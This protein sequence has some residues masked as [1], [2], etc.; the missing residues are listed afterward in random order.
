MCA[1]PAPAPLAAGS[2]ALRRVRCELRR[3]GAALHSMR[4][5]AWCRPTAAHSPP[6]RHRFGLGGGGSRG[7]RQGACRGA[8][9]PQPAACRGADGGPDCRPSA[10]RS[11]RRDPGTGPA[12]E[13]ETAAPG[14]RSGR[15]DR[16]AARCR[17][18]PALA[19]LPGK[20]RRAAPGRSAPGRSPRLAA[21]RASSRQSARPGTA[22]RR[23]SDHRSD[24]LRLR[25]CP[26]PRRRRAGFRGHVR[27]HSLKAITCGGFAA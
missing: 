10:P 17:G 9:I 11:A 2:A 19:V 13:L 25:P 18:G 23:R 20:G 12:G 5:I 4:E 22:G 1:S 26:A 14:L 3:R 27:P 21:P 16:C 15:G 8:E 7:G 6:A 24:T